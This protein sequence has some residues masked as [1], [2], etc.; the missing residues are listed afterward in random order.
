MNLYKES[1]LLGFDDICIIP[2][3]ETRISSRSECNIKRDGKLPL[4]TA[5]MSCVVNKDNLK[6][7]SENNIN[8]IIPRIYSLEERMELAKKYDCFFA[9]SLSEAEQ[10]IES[11]KYCSNLNEE[12]KVCIDVANGHMQKLI[13]ICKAFKKQFTKSILMAGNIA[14]PMTYLGYCRAEIDYVRVSIGSGGACLTA[15]NTACYMP[16]ASLLDEIYQLKQLMPANSFKTKIIADG[17]FDNYDKIIKAFALGADYVMIGKLFAQCTDV[18]ANNQYVKVFDKDN[19]WRMVKREEHDPKVDKLIEN[20]SIYF[21]YYGM[22]TKEAQKE[23]GKTNLHTSE[24]ITTYLPISNNT[25]SGWVENFSDYLTSA[26]SYCDCFDLT[27]FHPKIGIISASS[28][29]NYYK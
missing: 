4:F 11:Y 17:G 21:K 23:M 26:M 27:E 22:S 10:L 24:G 5:P 13:D 2:S 15:C 6:I 9:I 18:S 16:Q 25:L 28:R 1:T 29:R 20:N 7:F 3:I 8:T 12:W 19:I 14:R